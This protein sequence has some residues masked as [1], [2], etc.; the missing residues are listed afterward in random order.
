[1]INFLNLKYFIVLT[2]TLNFSHAAK[3]LYISQQALSN[4]ISRLEA[5]YGTKLF[6]RNQP[7]TITP[8]GKS[9]LLY[10]NK[11][12]LLE[13][14]TERSLQDIKN[15]Q[16]GEV[17]IGMTSF[18]SAVLLPYILSNYSNVF[19]QIKIHL[20]HGSTP[21]LEKKLLEGVADITIGYLMK[22]NSTVK[23]DLLLTD[24][25][26]LAVPQRII[27]TTFAGKEKSILNKDGLVD[28]SKLAKCPFIKFSNNTKAGAI[29]D[30]YC[31]KKN[32][33]PN[34]YLE[35]SYLNTAIALCQAG[36]GIIMIPKSFLALP[37]S[38]NSSG[39][40]TKQTFT[41]IIAFNLD[42]ASDDSNIGIN[43]LSKKYQPLAVKEFIKLTK[44]LF[45]A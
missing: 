35:T 1:M 4:H 40:L 33:Q 12:M 3:K 27:S 32:F 37:Y 41:N 38:N 13:K 23:N 22:N 17:T 8:A 7:M 15:F 42:L 18:R 2:E 11:M 16:A 44:A 29:F 19:P 9:L 31:K 25:Y 6:D 36:L 30:E 21:Q 45:K 20:C 43:Y 24:P 28:I 5:Y 34:I 26:V 14:E 10:A 39:D